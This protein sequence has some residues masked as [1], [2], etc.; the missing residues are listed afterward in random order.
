MKEIYITVGHPCSKIPSL[1]MVK[2]FV[3]DGEKEVS[4]AKE[5]R[6]DVAEH[7]Q[8]HGFVKGIKFNPSDFYW[9]I[10]DKKDGL[11]KPRLHSDNYF[12]GVNGY[13]LQGKNPEGI[14]YYDLGYADAKKNQY[15]PPQIPQNYSLYMQGWNDYA[16][17]YQR[18]FNKQ[19][20]EINGEV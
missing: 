8:E 7:P 13:E 19:T 4:Y 16:E 6:K 2:V 10:F 3:A 17:S 20:D 9:A 12:W 14:S 15:E 18:L 11:E 5:I 1:S